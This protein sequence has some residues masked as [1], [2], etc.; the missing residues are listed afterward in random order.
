MDLT[1]HP[2]PA[3]LRDA[4]A[5]GSRHFFTGKP[6]K[7]LHFCMRI[8]PSGLCLECKRIHAEA[9]RATKSK[10]DETNRKKREYWKRIQEESP[11]IYENAKETIRQYHSRMKDE[12][13]DQWESRLQKKAIHRKS[14]HVRKARSEYA[15]KRSKE[16]I[17]EGDE[18]Y[19]AT[20]RWRQLIY[21]TL[22]HQGKDKDSGTYDLLGYTAD[23]LREHMEGLFEDGMS[24]ANHGEWHID[25]KRP[26]ASFPPDTPPSV[27]NS[28]DNLQPLWAIDNY[29]KHAKWGGE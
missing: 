14:P 3:R 20:L 17:E 10:R 11:E 9:L 19:I 6:C 2:L 7:R 1:F 12:D 5:S 18:Q 27:V 26:L 4:K 15:N 22:R 24:W 13:P 8:S 28:L 29:R 25:H 23:Q 16:R 21:R